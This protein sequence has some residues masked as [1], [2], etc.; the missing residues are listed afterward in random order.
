MSTRP[1]RKRR[2][3]GAI[4]R[5]LRPVTEAEEKETDQEQGKSPLS[6]VLL[7]FGLPLVMLVIG[8]IVLM[9]CNQ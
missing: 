5:P 1:A 4:T 8:G 6:F 9:P 2:S 3:T 7:F